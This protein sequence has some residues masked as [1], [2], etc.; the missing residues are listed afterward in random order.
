MPPTFINNNIAINISSAFLTLIFQATKLFILE[1]Q[2]S[3]T[4]VYIAN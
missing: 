2:R 3:V 1:D 4:F